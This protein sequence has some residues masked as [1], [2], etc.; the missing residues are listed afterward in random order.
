MQK[1]LRIVQDIYK[2]NEVSS[3]IY[4]Y[5]ATKMAGDDYDPYEQK[6]ATYNLNPI[7]IKGYVRE[8]NP[9][10]LVWKQYGLANIG[11]KEVLCDAKYDSYFRNCTKI[12]IDSID[13]QVFREG[14]GN[15][16]IIQARPFQTMR[17]VIS[18][19]N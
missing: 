19:L 13:Y 9:E 17:V 1:K 16:A 5:F 7:V 4:I 10:A 12:T 11:A 3:K 15:K 6:M 18:R 14:A 2:N 8:I